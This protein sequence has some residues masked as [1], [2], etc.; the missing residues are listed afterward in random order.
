LTLC[1]HLAAR[2]LQR[3]TQ[4]RVEGTYGLYEAVDYTRERLRPKR[5]AT[6]SSRLGTRG[7]IV[8][9]F[10]AH[11]QG[12]SLLALANC[13]LHNLMPRRFHAEPMVRATELLLQER[14]PQELP[15]T[16]PHRDEMAFPSSAQDAISLLSRRLTT[17]HTAHPRTN[18]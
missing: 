9:C 14:V 10:M 15:L 4:E 7:V 13:L 18:L 11:H 1:P 2:N 8:K 16:E 12:M 3:L 5:H 17:P 6:P